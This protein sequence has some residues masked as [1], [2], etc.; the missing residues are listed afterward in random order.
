MSLRL[1][2]RVPI[3]LLVVSSN[4]AS[5]ATTIFSVDLA[6]L[7]RDVEVRRSFTATL[8]LLRSKQFEPEL[9]TVTVYITG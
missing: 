7:H 4:C 2:I 1:S 5:A 9:S 8:T 6:H 3:E